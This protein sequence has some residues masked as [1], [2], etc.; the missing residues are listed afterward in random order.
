MA[1]Y[2]LNEHHQKTGEH[3]IH[4]E[5]CSWLEKTK[6][7][8]DLGEHINCQSAVQYAKNLGYKNVDGCEYCSLPCHMK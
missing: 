1:K 3:E 2:F 7:I 8:R 6:K 4:K 5:G